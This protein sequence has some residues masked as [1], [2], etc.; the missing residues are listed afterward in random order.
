MLLGLSR[1]VSST[2]RAFTADEISGWSSTDRYVVPPSVVL[3]GLEKLCAAGFVQPKGKRV[4]STRRESVWHMTA[5]GLDLL[6]A[7]AVADLGAHP[8]ALG[9]PTRL[10]NLLRIRKRLTSEEAATTLIDAGAADFVVQKKRMGAILSA[11]AKHS[12][13]VVAVGAR[14][15]AGHVRYV[16]RKDIGRWPPVQRAGDV[17]PSV[18]LGPVAVPTR[19]L[20]KRASCNFMPGVTQ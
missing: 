14:R 9:L 15:E 6:G 5:A 16:L 17:H 13:E 8:N 18:F 11:W 10:W 2:Q 7:A 4:R 20:L 3:Q 19:F 12:P 1:H